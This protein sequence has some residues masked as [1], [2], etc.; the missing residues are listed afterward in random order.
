MKRSAIISAA[1][2]V[3]SAC[4]SP[5]VPVAADQRYFDAACGRIG[6]TSPEVIRRKFSFSIDTSETVFSG[7]IDPVHGQS[8][9]K[10]YSVDIPSGIGFVRD[11]LL[12]REAPKVRIDALELQ[13]GDSGVTAQTAPIF[14]LKIRGRDSS[15]RQFSI[16]KGAS[17]PAVGDFQSSEKRSAKM[18][19]SANVAFM[20][21]FLRMVFSIEAQVGGNGKEPNQ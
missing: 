7:P 14:V 5:V 1:L 8:M 12:N 19:E 15:G 2:L 16:E 4:A 9:Q 11:H 6:M 17:G 13:V 3:L 20:A 21:A 18:I 10:F